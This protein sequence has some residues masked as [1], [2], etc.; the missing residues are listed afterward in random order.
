MVCDG[1]TKSVYID[2]IYKSAFGTS[3]TG[4]DDLHI[5]QFNAGD[6]NDF[7]GQ[8]QDLR[9][10]QGTN[11]GYTGT[12]TGARNFVI[13]GPIKKVYPQMPSVT[14]HGDAKVQTSNSKFGGGSVALDG[15][16]DN[17]RVFPQ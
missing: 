16:G 9:V 11:K 14:A 7:Q 10:Y 1:G 3:N 8:I 13:P 15:T 5:G 6:S 12:D 17:L 2:A 4:F